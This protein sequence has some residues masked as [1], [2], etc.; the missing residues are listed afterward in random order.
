MTLHIILIGVAGTI[1]NEHTIKALVNLGLTIYKAKSLAFKLSYRAIQKLTTIINARHAL[2]FQE[3]TGG[4]LA[5]RAAVENGRGRV[6]A[7]RSMADN[8][9]DPH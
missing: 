1:Y 6:R 9:P 4:K 7:P 3:P 2:H 5:G 8:P